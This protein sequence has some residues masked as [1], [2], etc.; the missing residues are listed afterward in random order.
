MAGGIPSGEAG[1]TPSEFSVVGPMLSGLAQRTEPNIRAYLESQV[2]G[3]NVLTAFSEKVF[4]GINPSL[5]IV[6]GII[7]AIVRQIID[8]IGDAVDDA[9]EWIAHLLSNLNVYYKNLGEFLGSINFL[10]PDF[11]PQQAAQEFIELMI[12]PLNLLLGPDSPINLA[13]AFGVLPKVHIG[14]ITRERPNLIQA[15]NFPLGSIAPNGDWDIDLTSRTDDGSG[16]AKVQANGRFKALRSGRRPDDVIQVGEGQKFEF[17]INVR[18]TDYVGN[19]GDAIELHVVPFANGVPQ[20]PVKLTS[21]RPDETESPWPGVEITGEWTVPD[22]VDGIQ[23][24]ILVTPNALEGWFYFDDASAKQD[25]VFRLE[26]IDGLPEELQNILA[27]WQATLNTIFHSLTGITNAFTELADIAEALANIPFQNIAGVLGPGNLGASVIEAI[28][29]IVGGWVGQQGT[30]AG[31]ADLFNIGKLIS[32]MASQGRMAWEILGIR[33]NRPVA[34]GLLPSSHAN[35]EITSINTNLETTQSQSLIGVI[36][37]AQD[38]PLGLISWLGCGTANLTAFYINVW[39]IDPTDGTRDLVHHS[40]NLIGDIVSGSTPDWNFYNLDTSEDGP[41]PLLAGEDYAIE[42][43]P[44]GTGSHIIRGMSTDDDIPDHPYAQVV[45]LAAWRDNSTNPN[46]P[47][48]SILKANWNTGQDIPWFCIAIDTSTSVNYHDPLTVPFNEDGSIVVPRW[49]KYVD[50]IGVGGGGGSRQGGTVGFYG[51]PGEPGQWNAVTW[52]RG[53]DFSGDAPTVVVDIGNGGYGGTGNGSAG[54]NTVI[55]LGG[56]TL[57]CPGGAGGTQLQPIII[58]GDPYGRGPGDFE[59]NDVVYKGG[60]DQ[61]SYGS[62]GSVPGG[63]AMGGNWLLFSPGAYGGKGAVWVVFRDGDTGDAI[64]EAPEPPAAPI[65][66]VV[67]TTYS[68]IK[69]QIED[70]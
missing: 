35:Y 17:A 39:Y 7:D 49:A 1:A 14:A 20:P 37:V 25:V 53:E 24:R 59:Y 29:A 57:V 16:S 21:F 13:N 27:H 4:A 5:G 42:F 31:I 23:Q 19:G 60:V 68:T 33:N 45:G 10:S 18:W 58:G 66:T 36:R 34:S 32:S 46:N 70:E 40:P 22:G 8:G 44:V 15:G 52:V 50:V 54:Q 2:K 55:T 30:G 12:L 63:G 69:I 6:A 56:E 64:P 38:M 62:A 48:A 47:P 61:R 65:V 3:D 67:E 43:V 26:W 9:E 41:L 51:E 11:N 28:N